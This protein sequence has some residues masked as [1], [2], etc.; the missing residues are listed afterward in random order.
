MRIR[1]VIVAALIIALLLLVGIAANISQT[2]NNAVHQ[3]QTDY[4]YKLTAAGKTATA[5]R[6]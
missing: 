2:A 5:G 1:L 3:I 6:R 4:A